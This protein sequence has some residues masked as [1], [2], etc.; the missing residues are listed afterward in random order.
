MFVFT[1]DPALVIQL[2]LA[3]LLPI[4]VGLVT[5]RVTSSAKKAILLAVLTLVT[6]IVTGIGDAIARNVPFDLGIALLLA[7]PQFCISVAMHYGLWKPTGVSAA[8]QDVG[9]PKV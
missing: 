9:T 8:V 3:V 7:L 5:T 4:A 1:L 6:S 2:L